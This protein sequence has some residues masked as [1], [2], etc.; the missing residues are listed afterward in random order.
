MNIE[1]SCGGGSINTSRM[2][3]FWESNESSVISEHRLSV[4]RL[5]KRSLTVLQSNTPKITINS[6][7]E[8]DVINPFINN[9]DFNVYHALIKYVIA[10]LSLE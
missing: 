9:T 6:T 7:K 4:Q 2:V 8:P 1:T 10:V 3:A 5:R